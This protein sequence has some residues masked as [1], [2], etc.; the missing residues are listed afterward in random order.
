LGEEEFLKLLHKEEGK[1]NR[2][3]LAIL[4]NEQ[5]AWDALQQA[6]ERA[7]H[8]RGTLHGGEKAFPAWMKRIL[9]N[10]SLNILRSQK[11]ITPVDPQDMWNLLDSPGE[12]INDMGLIWELVL[13]LGEEHRKVVVLRYLGGLSLKEIASELGIPQGTVKS[14]LNTAHSRLREKLSGDYLEGRK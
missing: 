10:Q 9:V 12:D 14:R 13:N 3:A 1:L 4:C 5:D 7:W 11:K 2:I 6:T 8:G